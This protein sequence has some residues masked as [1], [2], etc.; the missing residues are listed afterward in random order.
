MT[1]LRHCGWVQAN[2]LM[3]LSLWKNTILLM[4]WSDSFKLLWNCVLLE[5]WVCVCTRLLICGELEWIWWGSM[6]QSPERLG[7]QYRG[8]LGK[9]TYPLAKG[10]VVFG[11]VC[12]LE[13]LQTIFYDPS[14]HGAHE[15]G[16]LPLFDLVAPDPLFFRSPSAFWC[17]GVVR[18]HPLQW[19]AMCQS[20]RW[21]RHT[22]TNIVPIYRCCNSLWDN[23]KI[24]L[25]LRV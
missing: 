21:Y 12:H 2:F 13:V 23:I 1:C 25:L 5:R 17:R 20:H 18:V 15:V 8:Q 16:Y 24:W 22:G 9:H 4:G 6:P 3:P 14:V 19:P 11:F 7:F 10:L